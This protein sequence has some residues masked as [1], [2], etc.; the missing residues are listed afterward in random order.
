MPKFVKKKWKDKQFAAGV[1]R[2]LIEKG[3]EMLGVQVSDLIIDK[4]NG[5]QDVAEQMQMA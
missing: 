3:V 2:S 5:T 1:D 4:I